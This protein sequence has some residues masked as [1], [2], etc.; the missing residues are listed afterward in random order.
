MTVPPHHPRRTYLDYNATTPIAPE[1]RIAMV[2]ALESVHG[3]PSSIHHEGRAARER[4]ERARQ[5]VAALL[6]AGP[7]DVVFT[8]GGTEAD[9][10]GMLGLYKAARAAGRPPRVLVSAI[11]HPAVHGAAAELAARGAELVSIDVDEAGRVRLDAL[12]RALSGGAAL[13]AVAL[14]NHELGTI[15]DLPAI[16]RMTAAAGALLHC[17][18]V[19]AVGRIAVSVAALR[20]DALALSAHKIYGPKGTGALWIRPGLDLAPLWPGGHQERERRPGTE[21][22]P[23]IAGLGAAAELAASLSL[24]MT[25]VALLG[26]EL[27][28]GILAL[29][30]ARVHG[31][32]APRVP[33]TVN[34]AFAGAPGELVTQA[35]DLAGVAVST[36]AA[37]TSGTV[38][39]SPVLLAL[40]L[41]AE[42]ALEGVRFSLGRPTTRSDIQ[43][44][45]EVLPDIVSR[46]RTFA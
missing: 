42:R 39:A 10:L 43:A 27:E 9:A 2:E 17:D 45:L 34:A 8:S 31:V 4:V 1:V 25:P 26:D 11:E 24:S 22:V 41:S 30:G 3:N 21:N 23:G 18:A 29:P 15:Q 35:L 12:E 28:R 32:G 33:G 13:V 37:C 16:A 5:R 7:E 14:A 36:G 44:L 19:Q 20:C 40:G 46:V 6:A 38:S